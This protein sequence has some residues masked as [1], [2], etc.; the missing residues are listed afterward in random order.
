MVSAP[1][2]SKTINEVPEVAPNAVTLACPIFHD[3]ISQGISLIFDDRFEESIVIFDR[4]QQLYPNH[5]A[6]YFFRAVTYQK[7]MTTFR[8]KSL[9]KDL[10]ENIQ[11]AIDKGKKW[12][13]KENDP[14]LHFYIGGAYGYRAF[15]RFSNHDWITAYF[16][17]KKGVK[18][19]EKALDK[20][21]ALYD[22][23]L[24]LGSYHYWRTSK[25]KF[26]RLIAFWM[27]DTRD[28][29]IRQ[30]EFSRQHGLYASSEAGYNLIAAYVDNGQNEKA[31]KL[32]N[33]VMGERGVPNIS[34]LYYEGRLLILFNRWEEAESNFRTIL[35]RLEE[36]KMTTVGY[37]V[38]C[39]YLIATSLKIQ[40]RI[41]QALQLTE[42]AL[43]Q[44][45]KWNIETELESPFESFS[46]LKNQL[47]DLHK[48]LKIENKQ[49]LVKGK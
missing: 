8:T 10:D 17:S 36:K 19:F 1:V 14:W 3:S 22:V 47:K 32:L 38:E 13:E 31:F 43:A 16:D 7:W 15:N 41:Y 49:I 11:L 4:L 18:H 46:D 34:D 27:K 37:I 39:K 28:L 9:Q 26:L 29:G 5:P 30:L 21:P 20:E 40:N 24:G 33:S 42:E 2:L 48:E 6:P 23:Y 25:S 44:S 45:E 35:Q 12:L